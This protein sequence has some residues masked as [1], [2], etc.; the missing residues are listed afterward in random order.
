MNPEEIIVGG[1]INP[2]CVNKL[3]QFCRNLKKLTFE[4]YDDDILSGVSFKTVEELTIYSL[5]RIT[6]LKNMIEAFKNLKTLKIGYFLKVNLKCLTDILENLKH[7]EHFE[8]IENGAELRNRDLYKI[9]QLF[10]YLKFLKISNL[11]ES[12]R[13]VERILNHKFPQLKFS[14]SE[15]RYAEYLFDDSSIS[16]DDEN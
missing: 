14:F 11:L 13:Q 1:S 15:Y 3:S 6:S 8:E 12:L 9:L 10:R 2:R 5:S 4:N 16:S 7:L